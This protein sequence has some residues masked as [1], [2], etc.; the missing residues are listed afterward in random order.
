MTEAQKQARCSCDPAHGAL[1]IESLSNLT[2]MLLNAAA[3]FGQEFQTYG[4]KKVLYFD[5]L[6]DPNIKASIC[7]IPLRILGAL[8]GRRI[9]P[10]CRRE[11]QRSSDVARRATNSA[12]DTRRLARLLGLTCACADLLTLVPG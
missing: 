3:S 4:G 6:D 5:V 1:I 10:C 7:C 9:S 12:E 11:E 2:Q 8:T